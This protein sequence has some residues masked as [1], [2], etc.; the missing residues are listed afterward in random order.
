VKAGTMTV[1]ERTAG[2]TIAWSTLL[3][4]AGLS[5]VWGLNWPAMKVVL[6]EMP[7]LTFRALCLWITGPLMLVLARLGGETLGVPRR[8]WPALILCSFFNVTCWYFGTALALTL[9]PAGKAAL[10]AYTMPVMVATLSAVVLR[11]RLG[12]R[13]LTGVALGT[14]GV[15]VLILPEVEGLRAAPLGVACV[16][17]AAL[18]WAIGTVGLKF[19]RFSRSVTQLTG[20]QLL[21]GGLPIV[22]AA[23]LHDPLPRFSAYSSE[24]QWVF[25]YIIALPMGF[26]QWAWFQS[27]SRLSGTV[28]AI[29]SLA[30]PAVGLVSSAVLLGEGLG[31]GEALA[32][33]LFV[34]GVFL[35]LARGEAQPAGADRRGGS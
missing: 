35:V 4:L 32:L 12:A 16:L 24:T 30:V 26:G 5:L 20:W 9:I 23:A 29:A 6:G 1:A 14:A 21:I 17:G 28:A 15:A 10:L 7:V 18:G 33:A 27:L 3:L 25:V 19:F 31:G 34:A 22:V 13:R 2:G 8:E 11:E